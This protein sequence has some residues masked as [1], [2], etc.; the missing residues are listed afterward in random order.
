MSINGINNNFNPTIDGLTAFNLDDIVC[1]SIVVNGSIT[2]PNNSILDQYLTTNIPK[3]NQ[4][5]TFSGLNTYNGGLSVS[6]SLTLYNNAI[7]DSYLSS[8]VPLKDANN[9]Y[10]GVND[11]NASVNINGGQYLGLT[12]FTATYG[13]YFGQ[14]GTTLEITNYGDKI[15]ITTTEFD[16]TNTY[17]TLKGGTNVS[18]FPTYLPYTDGI[19]YI[20]GETHLRVGDVIIDDGTLYCYNGI[21]ITGSV[22]LPNNS[23]SDSALS[24]NVCLLTATQTLTNKT[25]TSPIISTII[26][27]GT[28]TLPTTTTTLVGRTT[29]DTLTNK[30]LTSPI[31]STIINTGTLTLPTTTTT[32]VGRT[33]TDTLR[34]EERR[35]GKECH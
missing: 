26:N 35:V 13:T 11:F 5:N 34:S 27:T 16:L 29:T 12:D 4:N 17:T 15:L 24:N 3:K 9:V 8:N 21:N 20:S 22:T 32:L 7:I 1:N 18:S 19:N 10:S 33:T 2:L 30:T 23:I 31:I 28:L 25:L 14:N 6:S